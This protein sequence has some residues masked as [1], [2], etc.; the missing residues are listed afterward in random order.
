MKTYQRVPWERMK[1]S[2]L[3]RHLT[4]LHEKVKCK[5]KHGSGQLRTV[6]ND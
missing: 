2:G 1:R 5:C 4:K 3:D 6:R